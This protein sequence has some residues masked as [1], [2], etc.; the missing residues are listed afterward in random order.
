MRLNLTYVVVIGLSVISS[1]K[2]APVPTVFVKFR[3]PWGINSGTP[4]APTEVKQELLKLVTTYATFLGIEEQQHPIIKLENTFRSQQADGHKRRESY[5][6]DFNGMGECQQYGDCV[7]AFVEGFPTVIKKY[8]VIFP[9]L[10]PPP[11]ELPVSL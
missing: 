11:S 2:A 9:K 3:Q 10:P 4:N 1:V 8:K 6:A 7:V 5:Q